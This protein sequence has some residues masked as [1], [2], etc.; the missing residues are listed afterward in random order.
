MFSLVFLLL[1]ESK[2]KKKKKIHNAVY[3]GGILKAIFFVKTKL[4]THKKY[5]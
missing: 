3:S 1:D 5:W 4:K 2:S